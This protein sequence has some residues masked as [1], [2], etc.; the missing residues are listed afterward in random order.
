PENAV[1]HD[2]ETLFEALPEHSTP[3]TPVNQKAA[4]NILKADFSTPDLPYS[5]AL[6]INCS[7]LSQLGTSRYSV[8]RRFRKNITE[9]VLD[10][11]LETAEFQKHLWRYPV[12][13]ETAITYFCMSPEEYDFFT[14]PEAQIPG[15]PHQDIPGYFLFGFLKEDYDGEPW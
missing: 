2:P 5:Q 7:Y 11:A 3:S 8:S 9:F 1:L 6:D 12:R 15:V 4:Y 13:I 10:P 14:G